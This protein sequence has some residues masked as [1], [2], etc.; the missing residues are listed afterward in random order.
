LQVHD[1]LVL[2]CPQAELNETARL[3]RQVMENAYPIS[4]PLTTDA[5]WGTDWD[6]LKPVAD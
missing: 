5:S 6:D 1:E 2:E 3:V 4:I